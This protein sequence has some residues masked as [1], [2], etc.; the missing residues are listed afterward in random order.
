MDF[1]FTCWIFFEKFL[2]DF[3]SVTSNRLVPKVVIKRYFKFQ[4]LHWEGQTHTILT[5]HTCILLDSVEKKMPWLCPDKQPV[6]CR[7]KHADKQSWSGDLRDVVNHAKHTIND[8]LFK[9][10]YMSTR[11]E[12]CSG[13]VT[14]DGSCRI[15]KVPTTHPRP[16]DNRS[17]EEA[18]PK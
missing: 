1:I 16:R 2:L 13:N 18:S 12:T 3:S 6:L 15:P 5:Y 10:P 14:R 8:K 7:E 9:S 11:E 17:E 4:T